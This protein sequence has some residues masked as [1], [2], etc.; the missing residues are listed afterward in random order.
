[1]RSIKHATSLLV[2]LAASGGAA[3]ASAD[4]AFGAPRSDG[5][6]ERR[7]GLGGA[8][9]VDEAEPEAIEL[10]RFRLVPLLDLRLR[11]EYRHAPVGDDG[12]F[13]SPLSD[14]ALLWER[15]RIGLA[16]ERGLVT[17]AIVLQDVRGIGVPSPSDRISPAEPVLPLTEPH[18]AYV[19]LHSQDRSFSVR[20]GR[21]QIVLGDGRLVGRSDDL[22]TGRSFDALR[23]RLHEGDFELGGFAAML[24]TPGDGDDVDEEVGPGAQLYA[25]DATWH[26]AP[27]FGLELTGLARFVREPATSIEPG[28]LYVAALRAFGEHRGLRYSLLGAFQA[29]RVAIE[30]DIAD[31]LAG[32]FAGRIEWQTALPLDLR[33][34]AQGAYATGGADEGASRASFDPLYADTHAHFGQHALYSWS[35]LVEV[36]GDVGARPFDELGL[37]LSYRYVGLADPDGPW[38]DGFGGRIAQATRNTSASLGHLVGADVSARPFDRFSIEASYSLLLLGDGARTLYGARYEPALPKAPDLAHFAMLG[39]RA[40]LP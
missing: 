4:D 12:G 40:V 23:V 19:D 37:A 39:A 5:G 15:A 35:N 1:M 18:E 20:L 26:A 34:G 13:R 3:R 33:F 31:Q 29:G 7:L 24:A 36:G 2:L 38:R 22:A 16:V 21:Q 8:F 6:D 10:E 9:A 11:A 32:A 25:L 30:G 27:W 14:H 28:D 17:A